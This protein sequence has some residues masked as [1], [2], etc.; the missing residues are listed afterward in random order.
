M[1]EVSRTAT[2]VCTILSARKPFMS[3]DERWFWT[4]VTYAPGS[5]NYCYVGKVLDD[6]DNELVQIRTR[7]YEVCERWNKEE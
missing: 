7:R 3:I 2:N 6:K 4:N 1:M 5:V